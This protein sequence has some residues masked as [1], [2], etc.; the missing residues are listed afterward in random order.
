MFNI[1]M[2]TFLTLLAITRRHISKI[3]KK[4]L[5]IHCWRKMDNVFAAEYA[6]L[7]RSLQSYLAIGNKLADV[8]ILTWDQ[9]TSRCKL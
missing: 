2:E 7:Q 4:S 5:I 6:D 3:E 8:Q 1:P 9:F